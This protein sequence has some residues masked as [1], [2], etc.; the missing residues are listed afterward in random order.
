MVMGI[1]VRP[2]RIAVVLLQLGGPDSLGAVKPYLTNF[3]SDPAIISVGQPMR[4]LIA[5][6]IAGRRAPITREIYRRIGGQSPILEQTDAQRAALEE[7]LVDYGAVRCFMAMRYWHPFAEDTAQEVAAWAPDETVLLPLYPQ[8]SNT[9]TG[10]ALKDWERA[11]RRVGLTAP[12]RVVREYPTEPGFIEA[13]VDLIRQ[14]WPEGSERLPMRVLFT[15][16]GLPTSIV[17]R[18][19]PYPGQ[20]RQTARAIVEGLGMRD[21]DW[22]L[23]YQSRVTPQKW[24]EPST[25][26]EIRRAGEQRV[27]LLVVPL[28]FV[29]E[30]SETLVELD[31]EYAEIAR[32]SRVPEYRRVPA[33]GT[34]SK[35]ISGLAQ[36]VRRSARLRPRELDAGSKETHHELRSLLPSAA[37]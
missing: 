5:K 28:S 8:F 21:L 17:G 34:H 3:F 23:A 7:E 18:G 13:N 1:E 27:G 4:W 2:R 24:L 22:K 37:Q 33:V 14:F 6:I 35:F 10:S 29:S 19:D 36:L 30:H 15:A 25:E 20:V 9:T 32:Q 12:V 11:E 31:I 26:D 16:H